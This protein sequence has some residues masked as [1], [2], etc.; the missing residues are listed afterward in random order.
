MLNTNVQVVVAKHGRRLHSLPQGLEQP[1]HLLVGEL[2]GLASVA[3]QI[4]A[5]PHCPRSA[6]FGIPEASS[7]SF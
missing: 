2:Q 5:H 3:Q 7:F 1:R 4:A 6:L